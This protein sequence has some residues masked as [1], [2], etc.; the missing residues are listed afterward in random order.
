MD[1]W[2][3]LGHAEKSFYHSPNPV[4]LISK[5]GERTNL[6]ELCRDATPACRLNPFLFNGHLQTF[7]TATKSHD[8]PIYYKRKIF[9]AENPAFVGT[10]AV[11]FVVSP[12]QG[13]DVALPPRTTFYSDTE[14]SEIGSIDS[15]PM[16]VALHGLSGGSH[17]MYLRAAIHPIVEEGWEAL[18]INSRGCAKSTLTSGVL[19]NARST[20]DIRQ[21]VK[22]LRKRF[23]NRPLF[24]IGFSL[25]AN[26]LVNVRILDKLAL[27]L[28]EVN[29]M[30]FFPLTVFRRGR[31]Q[32]SLE[33]CR[34]VLESMEFGGRIISTS[35]IMAW[36]RSLFKDDGIQY[37][38]SL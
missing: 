16:L 35:K 24:G 21:V 3:L 7:W 6:L 5:D 8:I 4:E 9:E 27:R 22:W 15:K 30:S 2:R 32:M 23:P 26:I 14:V 13:N 18:V 1:I 20:W 28:R 10:F 11:D 17:E 33:S 12:Y 34:S 36:A 37:E 38:K 19:Y 29:L 25:G 31:L